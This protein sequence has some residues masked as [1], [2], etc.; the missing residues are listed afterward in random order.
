MT[1]G[2]SLPVPASVWPNAVRF[3]NDGA[4]ARLTIA[5]LDD[6]KKN[7]RVTAI[8][9]SIVGATLC[10]R[11]RRRIRISQSMRRQVSKVWFRV[12]IWGD[13][14]GSPLHV[15]IFAETLASQAPGQT[16]WRS[17]A[18]RVKAS[19]AARRGGRTGPRGLAENHTWRSCCL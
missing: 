13:H 8:L 7:L 1:I 17:P 10:G 18:R 14:R 4:A 9:I 15:I 3:R 19:R 6:F 12:A 5:R 16:P 11:P 2:L